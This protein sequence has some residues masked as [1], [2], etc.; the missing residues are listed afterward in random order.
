M[1]FFE[2][3]C[4]DRLTRRAALEFGGLALGGMGLSAL[5]CAEPLGISV[6]HPFPRYS[7]LRETIKKRGHQLRVLGY[8]PDK[9]PIVA[10]KT[11]GKKKPA[12]FISAGSHSTEHAGVVAAVELIDRLET[13]HEVWVIPTRD[14]IGLNGYRYALS[15]SLGEEPQIDSLKQAEALLREKGEVLYDANERLLVLIGERG[16]ANRGLYR[17]LEKGAKF[18]EPLKGRRIYFPSRSTDMPGAGP[19]ERAYTLIVTPDGEV[20]HLNRFH[21]TPWAPAEVRCARRLMADIQPGLT[22]DLHEYGGDSFWMSAR[23]QRTDEDEVWE[24]RMARQAVGALAA[25]GTKLAADD[26]SPGSFFEKLEP[27]VF[28][29]DASKRGEGLN[30]IDYAARKYGPG[31]T[32]ETGMRG[33]F[34]QRVRQHMLV[35]QTA[36]NV[37]E[38]RYG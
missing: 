28:W 10:I 25:S 18:L 31:F 2:L 11:G 34:Q 19:L 36:V 13:K 6:V 33:Q 24:R 29:L 21:D 32:I 12:I 7:D 4:S 14:P 23:R 22:F 38:E 26:Y 16:F 30:L 37:F 9:S 1:K 20:L 17:R 27:G 3:S 35:V 5:V 15:L 8:A